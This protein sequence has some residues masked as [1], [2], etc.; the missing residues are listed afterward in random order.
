MTQ[1]KIG[2]CGGPCSGKSTLARA[3]VGKLSLAGHN[4]EYV[5]EYA[6]YHINE[7][8]RNGLL[9][10]DPL[11][12]QII[13]HNQLKW[14]NAVPEE[15]QYVV[16]DSPVVISVVYTYMLSDIHTNYN[17]KTYYLQYY[18]QMLEHINRYQYLFYLPNEI[19]FKSDGTRSQD[20]TRAKDIGERI[21]AFLIF[22]GFN[23]K[24]IKGSLDERVDQCYGTITEGYSSKK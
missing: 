22:H 9:V 24:E 12:Q 17:H 10:R 14:E 3:L 6:R 23:W 15:V 7:C 5:S 16:S 8:K 13:L 2:I 20:A 4:T 18:E 11:H 1:T 19:E 21:R